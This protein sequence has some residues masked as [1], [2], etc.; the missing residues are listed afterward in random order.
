MYYNKYG[1][2][3]CPNLLEKLHS[4][5]AHPLGLGK[6]AEFSMPEEAAELV[7]W[8]SSYRASFVNGAYF[9]VGGGYLAR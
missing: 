6:Q 1:D 4:L 5:P 9:A 3:L 8:L 2:N 7:I